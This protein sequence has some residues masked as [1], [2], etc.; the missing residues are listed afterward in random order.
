M[1]RNALTMNDVAHAWRPARFMVIAAHPDD[2]DFGPAGTAARWIDEGSDGW[3]VCCTSGDAG[4][5]DPDADPLELAALREREQ[6]AAA[7]DRR[8]RRRDVPPHARRRARQRPRPA[9][10]ARPRDPDV[11]AGRGPRDRPDGRSSTATAGSTTRTTARPAWP[12]STPSTRPPATR[13]RSRR[14]PGRA[15]RRTG[16]A[17][18]P[19]L[20]ERAERPRRHHGDGRPQ[21]RRPRAPTRARSASRTSSAERIRAW[22]AEEGEAI[23]VAGGRGAPAGR[24]RRRRGRGPDAERRARPRSD[25]RPRPP[26]AGG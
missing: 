3:L 7:D 20:A 23:G 5:E 26:P 12:P 15:S 25:G 24:H 19:V 2:A 11:P 10:A 6:R 18:V 17:P 9:R 13:W 4:G 1:G 16:P 21:D 8:L 22:A 14:W